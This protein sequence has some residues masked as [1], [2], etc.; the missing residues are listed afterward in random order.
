MV[1]QEVLSQGDE[2][3]EI[4]LHN[5]FNSVIMSKKVYP[6]FFEAALQSNK[7]GNAVLTWTKLATKVCEGCVK[8]YPD[9]RIMTDKFIL[10]LA[11]EL[12]NYFNNDFNQHMQEH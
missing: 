10:R 6:L 12:S 2:D 11:L 5:T 1:E 3:F 7:D 8:V 9:T 4:L